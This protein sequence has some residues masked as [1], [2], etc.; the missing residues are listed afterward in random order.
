MCS[1]SEMAYNSKALAEPVQKED[2]SFLFYAGADR[3]C[4][5]AKPDM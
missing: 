1:S 2:G 3:Q 4:R 5:K